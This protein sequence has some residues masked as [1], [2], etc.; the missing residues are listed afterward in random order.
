MIIRHE[1]ALKH[2]KMGIKIFYEVSIN[3]LL[4]VRGAVLNK[5][6]NRQHSILKSSF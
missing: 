4:I 5:M 1:L 3:Y 2:A 6:T